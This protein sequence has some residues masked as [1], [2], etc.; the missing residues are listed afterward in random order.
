MKGKIMVRKALYLAA[1]AIG[2][3]I[4]ENDHRRVG[5]VAVSKRAIGLR[6]PYESLLTGG[7]EAA[8]TKQAQRLAELNNGA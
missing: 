7:D 1:L 8:L 5:G 2:I 3:Q 6:R 4:E